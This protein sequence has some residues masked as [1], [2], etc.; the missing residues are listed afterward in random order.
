MGVMHTYH[1][2]KHIV[3]WA[4]LA[5]FLVCVPA[6]ASPPQEKPVTTVNRDM[7][8]SAYDGLRREIYF[9][10]QEKGGRWT[11]PV[12]LTNSNADN[13]L[14]CIVAIPGGKKFVVW[15][16]AEQ[17]DLSVRYAIFDGKTWSEA[18]AIPGLPESTTM[19]FVAVDNAGAVWLVCAGNDGAGQDDIYCIRLHNDA[20]GKAFR[21]NAENNVPDVNPFIEIGQDGT[22]QVTWEGF[23]NNGYTLL[24]TRWL[25]DR[26]AEEQVL[27]QTDTEKLQQNRK[28][29]EEE[30]LPDFVEDRSMLFIRTNNE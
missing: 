2:V 30:T 4:V 16:A 12:Q 11:E 27:S 14:P 18:K 9:S 6:C 15:T 25:G 19:P 8:W 1:N 17:A 3:S 13:I 5:V 21:V 28:Q 26:W 22:I 7:V 24:S 10:S 23:R 20:W 29:A